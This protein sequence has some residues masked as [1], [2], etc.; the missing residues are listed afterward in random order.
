MIVCEDE[1]N[2]LVIVLHDSDIDSDS[3]VIVI[4]W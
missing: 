4:G 1:M 3:R 2:V